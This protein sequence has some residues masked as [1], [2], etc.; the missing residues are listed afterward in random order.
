MQPFKTLV[1]TA[2]NL[3]PDKPYIYLFYYRNLGEPLRLKNPQRFTQKIQWLKLH[4][5]MERFAPFADKYTVRSYVENKIGA[6]HI[7]PLIG[8]WDHVDDVPFD[9]LPNRFVLKLTKGCGYNYICKDKSTTDIAAIKDILRSWMGQNF[10]RQ[11]REPQYKPGKQRIVCEAYMEDEFGS[12]RDYKIHCVQGVPRYVQVDTD[13]FTDHQSQI[14]YTNWD[15][16]SMLNPDTFSEATTSLAKPDNLDAMLKM[17]TTLSADFPYVRVDL[18]SIK[19]KL[20]FGELTFTPGSGIVKLKHD[21]DI[22]FG[23]MIDLSAYRQPLAFETT[24]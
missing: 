19:N 12:L 22:E 9:A 16:A 14:R 6:K 13:R 17:A 5:N 3:L 10:Y 1:S 20:Y 24:A 23:K 21:A 8:V 7:I 2:I 15:K 4:G 18:Y 11:E